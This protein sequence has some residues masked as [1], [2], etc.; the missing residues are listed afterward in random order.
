MKRNYIK[1]LP[2]GKEIDALIAEKVMGFTISETDLGGNPGKFIT[3]NNGATQICYSVLN[4]SLNI[5]SAWDVVEKMQDKFSFVLSYDD[6]PS[7]DEHKW[8]C[9]FFYK[10]DPAYIDHEV[11]APTAPLAICR[12]ALLCVMGI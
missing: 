11:Y 2:A 5:S 8:S 12:V 6:P 7:D 3:F 4:Y 9:E 10:G 1:N